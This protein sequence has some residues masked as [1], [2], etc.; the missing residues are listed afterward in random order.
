M[1]YDP[2]KKFNKRIFD[3]EYC[4]S[5]L[6]PLSLGVIGDMEIREAYKK[7]CENGVFKEEFQSVERKGLTQ[8]L[9]FPIL[10]WMLVTKLL[11]RITLMI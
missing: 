6:I 4:H 3:S 11:K 10:S 5:S 1:G 2:K 7:L 8:A 9:D